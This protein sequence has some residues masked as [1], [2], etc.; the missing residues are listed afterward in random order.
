M[1]LLIICY[2]IPTLPHTATKVLEVNDGVVLQYIVK[3]ITGKPSD[4]NYALWK[5]YNKQD[6]IQMVDPVSEVGELFPQ[7]GGHDRLLVYK[8]KTER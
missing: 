4:E 7:G 6:W 2:N 1:H 5:Q 3:D 8:K